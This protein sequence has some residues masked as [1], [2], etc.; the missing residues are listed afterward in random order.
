MRSRSS[1]GLA[2]PPQTQSALTTRPD[3]AAEL[4]QHGRRRDGWRGANWGDGDFRRVYPF[5]SYF[6]VLARYAAGR[7]PPRSS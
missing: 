5:V 7:T 3:D 4:R 2:T 6:E 1:P